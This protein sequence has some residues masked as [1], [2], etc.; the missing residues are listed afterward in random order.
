[1]KIEWTDEAC[2]A[3]MHAQRLGIE[4][5]I[6]QWRT[7]LNAATAE[8]FR[9]ETDAEKVRRLEAAIGEALTEVGDG[10]MHRAFVAL[11]RAL[12]YRKEA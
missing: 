10:S 3:A 8:Q 11:S 4:H 12:S 2:R 1:M 6:T 9:P 7:I 5:P